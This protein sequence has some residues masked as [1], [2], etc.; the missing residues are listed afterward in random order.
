MWVKVSFLQTRNR[1][2]RDRDDCWADGRNRS[3]AS[4]LLVLVEVNL[5]ETATSATLGVGA[6]LKPAR[7]AS[8]KRDTITLVSS[9]VEPKEPTS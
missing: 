2:I 8:R 6:G 1:I 3:T 7:T 5:S 4:D 9:H